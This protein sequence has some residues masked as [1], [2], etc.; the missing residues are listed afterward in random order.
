[1]IQ[2]TAKLLK[3]NIEIEY[4]ELDPKAGDQTA[5]QGGLGLMNPVGEPRPLE[6]VTDMPMPGMGM[7]INPSVGF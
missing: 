1:M 7:G 6:P 4:H 2:F 3:S 5:P